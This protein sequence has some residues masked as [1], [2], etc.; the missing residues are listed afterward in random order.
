[1]Y[2]SD[3]G[4]VKLVIVVLPDAAALL[5][6]TTAYIFPVDPGTAPETCD[7]ILIEPDVVRISTTVA[8]LPTAPAP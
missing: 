1:M 7:C 2:K 6:P 3:L 5:I 8:I 4:R